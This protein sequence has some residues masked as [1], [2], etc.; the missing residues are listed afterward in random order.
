MITI[1]IA[2]EYIK[3]NQC[4]IIIHGEF[5]ENIL[6]INFKLQAQHN[7][8]QHNIILIKCLTNKQFRFNK[9]H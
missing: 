3:I 8:G 7:V 9:F 1:N 4:Y 6:R 5:P 2:A